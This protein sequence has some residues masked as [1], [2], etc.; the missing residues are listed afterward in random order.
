[1]SQLPQLFDLTDRIAIITG[2]AGLLGT[3]FCHTLAEAGAAVMIADLDGEAA[4]D[5]A[6]ALTQNGYRA[7]GRETDVTSIASVNEMVAATLKAYGRLDI[8]VN[9][10]ALDPKFDPQSN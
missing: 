2:G 8:L 3:E 5:L 6:D 7:Q 9:S 1:M 4:A 10:A